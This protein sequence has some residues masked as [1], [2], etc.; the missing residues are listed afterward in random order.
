MTPVLKI[1]AVC[2]TCKQSTP[3][4]P[5]LTTCPHCGKQHEAIP[6]RK[7]K[8]K[9]INDDAVIDVI[10]FFFLGIAVVAFFWM[11]NG[12]MMD[13]FTSAHNNMTQTGSIPLS[14]N[15]QNS[16]LF[17]QGAFRSI[18]IMFFVFSV[19][20]AIVYALQSRNRTY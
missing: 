8:T 12:A 14:D 6:A 5:T 4:S 2:G 11:I 13:S 9:R 1:L 18:P 7:E 17:L 15:R 10:F 20:V 16:L 19:V 3:W